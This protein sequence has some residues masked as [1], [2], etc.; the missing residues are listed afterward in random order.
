M[1][2]YEE[3]GH[4]FMRFDIEK[5]RSESKLIQAQEGLLKK[6]VFN[7]EHKRAFEAT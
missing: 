5:Q 2:V 4:G 6:Y 7:E 1:L 3:T